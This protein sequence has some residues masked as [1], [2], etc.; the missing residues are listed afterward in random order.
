M[1]TTRMRTHSAFQAEEFL[2]DVLGAQNISERGDQL[3]HSCLLPFDMHPNGDRNP[4]AALNTDLLLYNCFSCGGGTLLWATELIL[5]IS[6]KDARAL[7]G[8]NLSPLNLT[9]EQGMQ[10]LYAI[11]QQWEKRQ[12]NMPNYTMRIIERWAAKSKYLTN[13]RH[14]SSDVQ[15][16]MKTGVIVDNVDEVGKGENRVL[17]TQPRL[18]IPHVFKTKLV[19]WSMRK[20]FDAQAGPKYKHT[21]EFP[22]KETLYNYDLVRNVD[23]VIVVESPLSVLKLKTE[24]FHNCVATFG[25]EVNDRQV[26]LLAGFT[27]V[28]FFPDGDRAG[29][30]MLKRYDRRHVDVGIVRQLMPL[31]NT[32]IVD[33]GVQRGEQ[34]QLEFNSKDA[35]DYSKAELVELMQ[36]KTPAMLWQFEGVSYARG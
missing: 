19:G 10:E 20:L 1:R 15:R 5:G 11:E 8:H 23:T 12:V 35:A 4:S 6:S 30:G 32:F 34:G 31:T 2:R 14:I 33:H 24:G 28:V 13:E 26:E 3:H 16:E 25:A 17:I 21:Q 7:I 22:K 27:N 29:Y 36:T 18:V 9:R